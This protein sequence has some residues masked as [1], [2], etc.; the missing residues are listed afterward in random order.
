VIEQMASPTI[1]SSKSEYIT[2]AAAPASSSRRCLSRLSDS[3]E[4]DGTTGCFSFSPK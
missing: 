2:M 1:C 3:G 4:A